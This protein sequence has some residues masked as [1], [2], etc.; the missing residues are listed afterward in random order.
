MLIICSRIFMCLFPVFVFA[1]LFVLKRGKYCRKTWGAL[2][3]TLIL[4]AIL[5]GKISQFAPR[6]KDTVT[7]EALNEKSPGSKGA[8]IVLNSFTVDGNTE[9]VAKLEQGKWF[10]DGD[11]RLH[12]RPENDKRQPVG[13][14]RSVSFV[15]PVGKNRTLNFLS[16]PWVGKVF[17][18]VGNAKKMVIDTYSQNS[19]TTE[20]KLAASSRRRR[21]AD[22]AITLSVYMVVVLILFGGALFT[23]E[24][25]HSE[26]QTVAVWWYQHWQ[27]LSLLAV[28]VFSLLY[29][30]SF[31]MYESL[32]FDEMW[33]I[34]FIKSSL[35]HSISADPA[36]PP[37]SH[38]LFWAWYHLVPYGE[39]WLLLLAEVMS[40]LAV[41]TI[42]M[43]GKRF[44]GYY[45]GLLAALFSGVSFVVT[46][47]CGHEIRQYAALFLFS[48]L[49]IYYFLKHLLEL[50]KNSLSTNILY[51]I[52]IALVSYSH[53]FGLFMMVP[54]FLYDAFISFKKKVGIKQL[55]TPYVISA[56]LYMPWVVFFLKTMFHYTLRWPGVPNLKSI[57][58]LVLYL[59]DAKAF[60][61]FGFA[62]G[63]VSAIYALCQR[64]RQSTETEEHSPALVFTVVFLIAAI[65]INATTIAFKSTFW[66]HRYFVC[67]LPCVYLLF[68]NGAKILLYNVVQDH[69]SL[70]T[71][72]VVI[73]LLPPMLLR[74]AKRNVSNEDYRG[75]AN[76]IYN[77]INYIYNSDTAIV[78]VWGDGV[79]NGWQEYYMTQ[80][81]R[82]DLLKVF[83]PIGQ[84]EKLL[85]FKRVYV[86]YLHSP[87]PDQFNAILDMHYTLVIDC[88]DICVRVYERKP[89]AAPVRMM[90]AQ[91]SVDQVAD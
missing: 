69:R 22:K 6:L 65:Y 2:A 72:I 83:T 76:F 4:A 7:L 38:I 10:W 49:T 50:P 44:F 15:I 60:I 62:V 46:S 16:N 35:G 64:S 48:A 53:Y 71:V 12:W 5:G 36:S 75:A 20:V 40:A 34:D 25:Y 13:C 86:Q 17:A 88:R 66:V 29:M 56:L 45:Q 31:V 82:R 81:R 79:L 67:L 52:C 80:Q 89:E 54:I 37:F 1:A 23:A 24:R 70:V 78:S 9:H 77:N 59:C 19:S 39:K 68:G 57:W 43:T 28:A 33:E 21:L 84:V 42:G 90:D 85:K 58:W 63:C 32:W 87:F 26:P 3:L 41:F 14:T 55:L 18:R 11:D 91:H 74:N 27:T 30:H 51:P 73:F 47:Q 61:L 8:E